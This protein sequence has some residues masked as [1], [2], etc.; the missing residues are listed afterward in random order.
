MSTITRTIQI[1]SLECGVCDITFGL[2]KAFIAAR[3]DDGRSFYCPN[4]HTIGWSAVNRAERTERQLREQLEASRSLAAR[5]AQRRTEAEARARI[6]DYQRR[7]AKGQLTKTKKRVTAGVCPCC[8]R[9][10]QNLARNMA[11]Q[12]PD[13]VGDAS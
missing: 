5:E 8:T 4:G 11:G 10:F 1:Q 3:Q 9:T 7:A 13:Y 2:T 12:H 6:A